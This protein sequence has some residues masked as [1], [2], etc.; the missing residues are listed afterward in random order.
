M[1]KSKSANKNMR[2][3]FIR[4]SAKNIIH[5][6]NEELGVHKGDTVEYSADDLLEILDSW[7]KTKRFSYYM[8]EHNED[9]ENQHFHIVIEFKNNSQ[10]KFNT[11]KS[12]FPY[13]HID[14]CRFGVHHCVRY[15][16]HA[17]NPEKAQY[18]WGAVYT[19]NLARLERYKQPSKSTEKQRVDRLVDQICRGDI[20]EYE[21]PDKIEPSLYVKYRSTFQ[22]ALELRTKALLNNPKRNIRVCVLQG[23]PR[24]GKSTFCKAW[25]EK[26]NKSICFSSA[27]RD[28]WQDY[29]GEDVFV[30]DDF[31]F[32][33]MQ[34]ADMLKML[35]PHV[36]TTVSSRYK[37]KL[38]IGDTI[39]IC[40]NIPIINWYKWDDFSRIDDTLRIALFKRIT[41]VFDFQDYKLLPQ[42]RNK[43]IEYG[44]SPR[45]G[46]LGVI[47]WY[48]K[49]NDKLLSEGIATYTINPRSL[50]YELN[51]YNLSTDMIVKVDENGNLRYTMD[52]D[53]Q[54]LVCDEDDTDSLCHLYK[55]ATR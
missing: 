8:A 22:N 6:D 28:I 19:N 23:P 30:L 46:E 42:Y 2:N 18:E 17:D 7:D 26:K 34:I 25:A 52:R 16:V 49:K 14:S 45:T 4:V 15:L 5:E 27:S 39:F 51:T 33:N 10:C 24:V 53:M 1:D 35:D 20:R 31:N 41:Y 40:T 50:H 55:D 13:G 32:N 47:T 3:A 44:E 11:L 29:R 9:E 48:D 54:G 38:F 36:S 12:K 21:F 43:V 37:N